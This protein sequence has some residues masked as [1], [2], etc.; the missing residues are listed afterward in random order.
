MICDIC[1]KK[2][3]RVRRKTRMYGTGKS[4]FLVENVPV[5]SCG[6]C[7]ES[8][9]T[10]KTLK[11]LDRIRQEWRRLA[12]KRLVPVAKFGGVL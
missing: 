1:G 12:V 2:A 8:Y 4:A 11:E 10:A 5:V 6:S 7:G 9:L 3:A